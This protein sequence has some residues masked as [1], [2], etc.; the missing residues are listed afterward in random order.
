MCYFSTTSETKGGKE[1]NGKG[2][3]KESS[4]VA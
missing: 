4:M 3:E 1:E 2:G